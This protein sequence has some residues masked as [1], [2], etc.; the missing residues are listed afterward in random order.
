[1]RKDRV[2]L[3]LLLLF[4]FWLRFWQLPVLPPGLWYDEAY[5]A[6]DAVWMATTGNFQPF[7]VGNNGREALWHLLLVPAISI[8]GQTAYAVRLVGAWAG[9]L[10]IPVMYC[11]ALALAAPFA[12]DASR[13]GRRWFAVAAAGWVAVSWWHLH[14]S[15]GGY[16]LILLPPLLM[17]SLYFYWQ[18]WRY[19]SHGRAGWWHQAIFSGLFLGISQY[20]YLPARLSPLI[21]AVL[22]GLWS[23]N[24]VRHTHPNR[25]RDRLLRWWS[26][27]I[28]IAVVSIILFLPLGFFYWQNPGTFSARTG[29]VA[30]TPDTLAEAAGH[31]LAA[32]SL[33]F[34]TGHE[35]YRHHLPGGRAMLGWFEIPLFWIGLITMVVPRRLRQSET[36]LILLG[37]G[38]MW[39]P[40]LLASPPVH[41]LRPIGLL[42]FY[43]LIVTAGTMQAARWLHGLTGRL[44][45]T[46]SRT[47]FSVRYLQVAVIVVLMFN[48]LLNSVS[49]FGS[50]A[51]HP[52]VYKEYNGPLADLTAE[53]RELTY[54]HNVIIPFH[55]YVHP[56]TRYLLGGTFPERK[57]APNDRPTKMLLVPDAFQLLLVG[58]I[59]LSPAMV[60]LSR[61][62][63]GAGQAAISRPPRAAESDEIAGLL[64]AN[65]NPVPFKDRLGRSVAAF[66][67][68][69]ANSFATLFTDTSPLRRVLVNWDNQ[70]EM[71]GYDAPET[72]SD[73]GQ[74]LP[75]NFYWRSLTEKTFDYK[76]FLQI[77][78]SQGEPINQWEG[79]AFKED[80]YRWRP[81][82]LLATQHSIWPD[83][84]MPPG[85][86]L[87]RLGFFESETNQRLPIVSLNGNAPVQSVDQVQLALF[88]V[89]SIP[90]PDSSV[91]AD[92]GGKLLLSGISV[93]D[94]LA[95]MQLPVTFYWQVQQPTDQPMT[96]FLQLLGED[97]T[98]MVGWDGQPFNGL[99]PTNLW[100]PGERVIDT[101]TLP[102]PAEG[103]PPGEYRLISGFYD[104]E[105]GQRLPLAGGGDF[106]EITRFT[107]TPN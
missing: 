45:A 27:T 53:L 94:D 82:G 91:R 13:A 22:T 29:D 83:P 62:E 96:V 43:Y 79:D 103:L 102:L 30:F 66:I 105:T 2:V 54:T 33:F 23:I 6:L 51:N 9:W 37:F 67:D 93:P 95:G 78:N 19:M 50:W 71:L 41:A 77:I 42:P 64:M 46:Y 47:T 100:S 14:N 80:M 31:G 55:V 39:L 63:T 73:L 40:A 70:A 90:P 69:P 48:G 60:R 17:L 92:F 25:R 11:F 97:G 4:G 24:I 8:W 3:L 89:G 34:G 32:L 21:I 26:A 65:S 49:Y 61:D 59:P 106:A 12:P 7:V 1:V 56:T 75:V 85:A 99:Y 87:M 5:N 52:E 18:V 35:L 72:V 104:F 10:T 20:T 76:L 74:P 28:L 68:L 81:D 57:Y 88:Y 101:F 36:Q 107:Y 58:N 86:Y 38:I 16:R 15:R 84:E 98:L 44:F